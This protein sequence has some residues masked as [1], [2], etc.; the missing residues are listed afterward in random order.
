MAYDVAIL[1][2]YLYEFFIS[3]FFFGQ[4]ASFRKKKSYVIVI[5]LICFG[6]GALVYMAIPI[7]WVNLTFFFV[8]NC[9]FSLLCFNIKLKQSVFLSIIMDILSTSTEY[10]TLFIISLVSG[11]A[12]INNTNED[13]YQYILIAVICKTLYFLFSLIL[14]RFIRKTESSTKVPLAFYLYP[15]T[16]ITVLLFLWNINLSFDLSNVH[17]I[18]ISVISILL[19]SSTIILFVSYRL[20]VDKEYKL[21]CLENEVNRIENDRIYYSILEK[22]NENLSIY[23]HDTKKHLAAIRGLSTNEEINNYLTQMQIQ[24]HEYSNTSHSGNH[25]LDVIIDRYLAE[26]RIKN[27]TFSF[28]LRL[29]NLSNINTFDLVSILGNVLD[30]ALES[31]EKSKERYIHLY[32]DYRNNFDIAVI[33][34]S[35]DNEP[36]STNNV[37]KTTKSNKNL[38]GLGMKSLKNTLKKYKGDYSWEYNKDSNE[39]ITTLMIQRDI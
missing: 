27:I 22:Q 18:L 23:V 5:G 11:N 38:H 14:I 37:L 20:S 30:N 32:T 29:S 19:L 24:L 28:D 17:K 3:L 39:F 13:L 26:C 25:F 35:C 10:I 1:M 15:V 2:V 8:I 31:A 21:L 4:I 6:C 33:K 9:I 36:I 16:T 7:M 12:V 34:N